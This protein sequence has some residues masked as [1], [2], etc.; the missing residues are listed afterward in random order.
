MVFVFN[1]DHFSIYRLQKIVFVFGFSCLDIY[2]G[3]VFV[4]GLSCLCLSF[5][6]IL[7]FGLDAH[8]IYFKTTLTLTPTLTVT[9]KPNP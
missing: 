3:F 8:I 5:H 2:L 7:A 9:H 6:L 1:L 4:F